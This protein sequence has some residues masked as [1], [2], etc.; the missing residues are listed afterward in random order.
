MDLKNVIWPWNKEHTLQNCAKS[1]AAGGK[2]LSSF[3]FNAIPHLRKWYSAGAER[4][5]VNHNA[6]LNSFTFENFIYLDVHLS[7]ISVKLP[8]TSKKKRIKE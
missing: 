1:D 2:L 7:K 3:I 5:F 8:N 4:I 6:Y